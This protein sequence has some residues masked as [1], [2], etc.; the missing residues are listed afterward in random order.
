[1]Q[2]ERIYNQI[3]ERARTRVL[4]GYSERHHIIPKCMGGTNDKSNLVKLTAKEHFICHM[5]L[6]RI[7]PDTKKLWYAVHAMS[8]KSGSGR[9]GRNYRVSS[10]Q[11]AEIKSNLSLLMKVR[12]FSEETRKKLSVARSG[13]SVNVRHSEDTKKKISEI[14]KG[15]KASLETKK[16]MS[17]IRKGRPYSEE[18]KRK[19]TESRKRNKS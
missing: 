13:R 4:E 11:Y 12:G 10:R 14:R 3:V 17:D 8:V 1:M 19:R 5:L 16:K 2:Y 9:E 18:T 6:C 15:T 7:Y